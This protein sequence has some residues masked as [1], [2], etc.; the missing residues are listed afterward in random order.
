MLLIQ[1]FK[2]SD[3]VNSPSEASPSS[4][5]WISGG[6]GGGERAGEGEGGEIG[7]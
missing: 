6:M 5:N 2:I 7:G 4:V 1:W 3:I